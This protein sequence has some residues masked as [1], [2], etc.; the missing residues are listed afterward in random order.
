MY[1]KPVL[2]FSPMISTFGGGSARGFNP[3]GGGGIKGNSANNPAVSGIEAYNSGLTTSGWV[4]I[5]TSTMASSK[6]VYCNMDD[7]GGGWMLLVVENTTTRGSY[8]PVEWF[9]GEGTFSNSFCIDVADVW[10]HNGSAQCDRILRM[11]RLDSSGAYTMSA[12]NIDIAASDRV[13]RVEYNEPDRLVISASA[14]KDG[15]VTLNTTDPRM[16]CTWHYVKGQTNA[17]S[18]SPYTSAAPC[19]WKYDATDYWTPCGPSSDITTDA[20]SGN[21]Q[22]TGM[23][24]HV[25]SD[26]R[27]GF[28]NQV[29]WAATGDD[30]QGVLAAMAVFCK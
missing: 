18:G 26:Q 6:Q 17:Q 19:D 23:W 7:D 9:S 12:G 24:T 10:Y 25:S 5:Q 4:W 28:G 11:A 29:N 16:N 14:T 22:G 30:S 21:G 13:H 3:G 2:L 1:K 15:S 20:R 27:Y 8:Y